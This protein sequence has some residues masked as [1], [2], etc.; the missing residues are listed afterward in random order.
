MLK[1]PTLK[2]HNAARHEWG[3]NVA[4][5]VSLMSNENARPVVSTDF[6]ISASF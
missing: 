2:M 4:I 3:G 5:F 6:N 1:V